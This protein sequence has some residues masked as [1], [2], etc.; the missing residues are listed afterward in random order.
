MHRTLNK[1]YSSIN[2]IFK[3]KD[4]FGIVYS[5]LINANPYSITTVKT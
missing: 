3:V 2:S 5:E 1:I 4:K